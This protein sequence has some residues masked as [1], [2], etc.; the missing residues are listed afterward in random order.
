MICSM[1]GC[2]EEEARKAY[3][4]NGHDVVLA[5]DFILF[6]GKELPSATKHTRSDINEH[7]AYLNRMRKT[8]EE[9]DSQVEKRKNTTS[10][11]LADAGSDETQDH[12]EETV[13]QSNCLPEYHQSV[14]VEEVEIPETEYLRR[15]VRSYGSA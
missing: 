7:E 13:Q 2:C 10:N 4:D 6:A 3:N 11:P 9:F 5:A 8:M 1:T 15:P 14:T 12:H